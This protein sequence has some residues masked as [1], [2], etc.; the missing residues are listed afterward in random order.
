VL[1]VIQFDVNNAT[2]RKQV[3]TEL[4]SLANSHHP[5]VVS[6]RQSYL[7]NGAVTILMEWMDGGSLADLLGKVRGLGA[8]G[9]VR[10]VCVREDGSCVPGCEWHLPELAARGA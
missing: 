6:Y 9:G 2:L 1:K 3:T 5:H 4:R 7:A 8:V 10:V